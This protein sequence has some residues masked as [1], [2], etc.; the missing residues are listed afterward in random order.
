MKLSIIG[1]SALAATFGM[2]AMTAAETL[3]YSYGYP[4][5]STVGEIAEDWAKAIEERTD[6]ELKVRNF[7]MSLLTLAEAGPGLRDG[8]ADIAYVVT[9][10]AP[11]DYSRY[12]LMQ[13]LMLT[14]NLRELTGKESLAY[15][16]AVVE[17]TI[18]KC[19]ECLDQ[20]ADQNQVYL[21]G[22]TSSLNTLMCTK[23]V[24]ALEDMDGLKVRFA[25][26]SVIRFFSEVGT[27]TLSFPANESY[28]G[29]SQGVADCTVLSM[30]D[31]TNMGLQD[32]VTH[33]TRGLPLG[34][35]SSVA[36]GNVNREVWQSLDE[37]KREALIWA[38]NILSADISWGYYSDAI[39]N[40]EI[41]AE[42]GIEMVEASDELVTRL[43]D[44]AKTDTE[45]VIT[46]YEDNY[47]IT[48]AAEMVDGFNALLE[49][50]IGLVQPVETREDL[51][52]L[53]WERVY[54]DL[55]PATYGL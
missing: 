36:V 29:L 1:A 25:L 35:A 22:A 53:F 49:E 50:W 21:S 46:Y 38:A 16:G 15:A 39:K 2:T 42:K 41:A 10:Y 31:L 5:Q 54:R 13:D 37:E 7:P 48:D 26:A 8:M 32:V 20:F 51:R 44:F 11:Q 4:K 14:L 19:P 30:P 3:K 18:E 17:Y 34:L 12:L 23:P 45:S 43:R 27:V 40:E 24:G 55:D 47:G 52:D 33:V 6:G 28:E 9:A